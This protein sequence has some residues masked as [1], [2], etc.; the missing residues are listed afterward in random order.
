MRTMLFYNVLFICAQIYNFTQPAGLLNCFCD[1]MSYSTR[2]RNLISYYGMT[3]EDTYGANVD[4]WP[5]SR[6]DEFLFFAIDFLA[7]STNF[8]NPNVCST[9]GWVPTPQ[10]R[11]IAK[12]RLRS[13]IPSLFIKREDDRVS[14]GSVLTSDD[15]SNTS[16]V[17]PR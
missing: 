2:V 9:K 5:P 12:P 8:V 13:T 7:L 1:K 16:K 14:E 10:N 11:T 15:G 17:Q 6:P 3:S 4:P